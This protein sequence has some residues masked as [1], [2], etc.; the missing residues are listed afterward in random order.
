MTRIHHYSVLLALLGLVG[1]SEP[2]DPA[3]T[4][5][6]P[7]VFSVG[8]ERPTATNEDDEETNA[9]E[10]PVTS[11]RGRAPGLGPANVTQPDW[12]TRVEQNQTQ[13]EGAPW[14]DPPS[15]TLRA[16]ADPRIDEVDSRT[17]LPPLPH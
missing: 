10:Q 11:S 1:C 2:L 12:E 7:I 9:E 14:P 13:R 5:V 6:G 16:P 3:P 15:A 17:G 8:D 4:P